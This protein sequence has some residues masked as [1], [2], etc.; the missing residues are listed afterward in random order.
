[1]SAGGWGGTPC[2]GSHSL[3]QSMS[4]EAVVLTLT[5]TAVLIKDLSLDY[6]NKALV[7]KLFV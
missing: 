2:P 3:H 4:E 7:I 5:Q 6:F 1:M